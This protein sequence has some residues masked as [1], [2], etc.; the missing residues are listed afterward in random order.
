MNNRFNPVA[1][2]PRRRAYFVR[3]SRKFVVGESQRDLP[4]RVSITSYNSERNVSLGQ[5]TRGAERG[6]SLSAG[7]S[8]RRP[9]R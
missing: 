9:V 3:H 1:L 2:M 6:V 7:Q 4:E 5:P 8:T